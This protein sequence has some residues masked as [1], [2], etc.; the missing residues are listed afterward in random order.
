MP[1]TQRVTFK[2]TLKKRNLIYIPKLI[3]WQYKLEPSQVLKVTVRVVGA[4]GLCESFLSKTYKDGR[5]HMPP[6]QLALLKQRESTLDGFAL[7]VSL[8]P[9]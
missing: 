2:T 5:I 4:M 9:A 6:L 8:E 1:L 7:E 3:R